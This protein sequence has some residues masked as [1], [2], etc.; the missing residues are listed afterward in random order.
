MAEEVHQDVIVRDHG[1]EVKVRWIAIDRPQ[2]KNGLTLDTNRLLIEALDGAGATPAIRA[3]VLT[4]QGGAFSSGLDLKAAA[5]TAAGA[6][7]DVGEHMDRWF[8][9]LIRAVRRLEKPVVAL[10]D[11][12]A[13]GF[14]C[15]LALAC[16]VR[17]GTPRA[18]F[19][20]L[21]IKR[22]LMPDGGGSFHL[23]RLVGLGN[24]LDLLLGGEMVDADRALRMGLLTR[25]VP[26]ESAAADTLAYA[27]RIAAGPPRV[28]AWIKRAVYGSLAGT[29]D[30]ALA[31]ERRGQLELLRSRDFLEG[32]AA[33]FEKREPKFTGE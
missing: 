29:L 28:H 21:F 3:V 14:G 1:E 2:S 5:T 7:S 16:D 23:P 31:T 15:D 30:D 32:V 20:E 11:G 27:M 25:I 4:G 18:R 12:G 9:G 26:V 19:G 33:F 8:H 13:V 22:G 17:L 24:A 6:M 10:V